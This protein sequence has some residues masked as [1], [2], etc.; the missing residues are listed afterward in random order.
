MKATLLS[1]EHVLK[2]WPLLEPEIQKALNYSSSESTTYDVFLT[3]L[4][5]EKGQCW[6]IF[7]DEDKLINVTT[8]QINIYDQYKTLHIR[9]TT[10]VGKIK[11]KD[12]IKYHRLL[13][14][15]AK[16]IGAVR[17]EMR[18]RPGWKRVLGKLIQ[19]KQEETYEHQY[20]VMSM[21][22]KEE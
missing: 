12:Y 22:L 7:D 6:V 10:S 3:C 11:L 5:P 4:N 13:E 2:Y 19:G 8:T 21:P 9:T 16:E 18:G 20:T 15:F 14:A 17:I 1:P